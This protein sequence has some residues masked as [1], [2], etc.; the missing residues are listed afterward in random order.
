ML[1]AR[2]RI[3]GLLQPA[4]DVLASPG[5]AER[6]IELGAGW[7]DEPWLGANREEFL[8]ALNG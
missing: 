3:A 7:R 5:V 8:R 4:A 1:R 2:L 6:V